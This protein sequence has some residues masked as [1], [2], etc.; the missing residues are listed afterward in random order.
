MVAT[1]LFALFE[2]NYS[3]E[4]E[5]GEAFV[6]VYMIIFSALLAAY[7]F[8]WWLPVP[9]I[10][11]T[12]RKNFG[13]LYGIKGKAMFIVF[14]AFLNFGLSDSSSA[15]LGDTGLNV[16]EFTIVLGI[17]MLVTG[18]LH[19]VVWFRYHDQLESYQSPT[20]GLNPTSDDI[21]GPV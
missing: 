5:Y 21:T 8:M 3:N 20:A 19:L 15:D 1:A 14:V 17:V 16:D 6:A 9:G 2:F 13:F 7:E 18:V 10:N 11:K 4:E 12:L